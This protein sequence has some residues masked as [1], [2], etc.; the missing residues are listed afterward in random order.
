M[1]E[2][3]FHAEILCVCAST[4]TFLNYIVMEMKKHYEEPL[5]EVVNLCIE[6]VI[7]S[8]GENMDSTEGEW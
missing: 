8:S 1:W 6:G 4:K 7:C 5:V 3:F 2:V